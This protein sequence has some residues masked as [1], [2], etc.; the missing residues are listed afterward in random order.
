VTQP[1]PKNLGAVLASFDEHW[2]PRTIALVNEYD[3]RVAK[4]IGHFPSHRHLDTDEFFLVLSGE[5]TIAMDDHEV[6]LRPGDTYVVP[7]GV[8]HQPSALEETAILLFEPST[9]VNTGD[10]PGELTA[11]RVIVDR[12]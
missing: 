1:I 2:A 12:D 7:R 8:R 6:R 10:R 5:L 3:V 4:V 9:T 11:P